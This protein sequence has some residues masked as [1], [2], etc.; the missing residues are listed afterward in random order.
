MQKQPMKRL[1]LLW[2]LP[3]AALSLAACTQFPDLDRTQ[4]AALEAADYPAL[5]PMEP[6]LARAAAPGADPVQTETTL[7]ARVAGLRGRANAMRGSVLSGVEKQ[8]L[9]QG[10]R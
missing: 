10:L 2:S 6:L 7:T 4:T 5:V 8:R 9:E 3:L 1:A